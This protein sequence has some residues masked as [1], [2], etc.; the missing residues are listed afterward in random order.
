MFH[1]GGR[2][3]KPGYETSQR[4]LGLAVEKLSENFEEYAL[5]HLRSAYNLAR[6]L[7]YHEQDA[8]D[9]VQ[10]AYLRAFK[11]YHRFR[12]GDMR[13]WLLKIVVNVHCSSLRRNSPWKFVELSEHEHNLADL[14]SVSPEEA[15]LQ[16]GRSMLVQK[17]FRKLPE[18]FQEVLLL[19]DF[20]EM[21]YKEISSTIQA[22]I[23]TVMSTLSR[24][25][26]YLRRSLTDLANDHA[27]QNQG[28]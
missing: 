25:R 8:D 4:R 5:P 20:H 2:S 26:A 24:A 16:K 18:R 12:G 3:L 15:L 21:S 7:T 1:A 14:Q 13:P 9:I 17:A 28:V 27:S 10:E 19:R 22:P 23:G 11:S 6:W